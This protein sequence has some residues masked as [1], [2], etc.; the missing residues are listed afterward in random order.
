MSPPHAVSPSNYT[1][2]GFRTRG[3]SLSLPREEINPWGSAFIRPMSG[4]MIEIFKSGCEPPASEQK[5]HY[6]D[7]DLSR[8]Q[9][10]SR[11]YFVHLPLGEEPQAYASHKFDS[12][13]DLIKSYLLHLVLCQMC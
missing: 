8:F 2:P 11:A 1:G 6:K 9:Y 5:P 12:V 4:L 10:I 3:L 7:L 13:S